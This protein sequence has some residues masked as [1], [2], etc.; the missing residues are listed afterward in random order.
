MTLDE[1]VFLSIKE[2]VDG[3]DATSLACIPEN[4]TGNARLLV[5]ENGI[6]AG[7]NFAEAI[8]KKID[9]R[10]HFQHLINDGS[11][12]KP[13]DIVFYLSGNSRS[14]LKAERLVLNCM[15]RMSGIATHANYLQSLINHTN[16]KLLDTRKTSPLLRFMEKS[17]VKIGGGHNH[18][19]GLYD[20]I[21]IKDNHIDY[22]GGIPQAIQACYDY[23]ERTNKK[24]NIEIEARDLN[25]VGEILRFVGTSRSSFSIQRIMLDN[26]SIGDLRSAVKTISNRFETEASGGVTSE[27]IRE[28]AETGVDFISVGAL[29]HHIKSLDLS[30]KAEII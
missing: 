24:L 30:L 14:I 25:E 11:R 17:A 22:A 18:R 20:M 2:D 16:A 28:I 9:P 8:F 10:M 4:A 27:T 19:F 1:F 7:V 6:I 29:T 5:K 3:G 26:F 23:L 13:G 21:M 15:Q 12:I